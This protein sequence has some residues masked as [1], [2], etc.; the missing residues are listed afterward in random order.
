M[1]SFKESKK[2]D[3]VS[4]EKF[5][6][7]FKYNKFTARGE[8]FDGKNG[9]EKLIIMEKEYIGFFP[10]LISLADFFSVFYYEEAR[11]DVIISKRQKHK[12]ISN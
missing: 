12:E 2:K 11:K 1:M 6:F 9:E 7:S 3:Y 10:M 4:T 8:I 5:S